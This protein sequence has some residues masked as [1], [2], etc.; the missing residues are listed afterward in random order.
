MRGSKRSSH[1]TTRNDLHRF[2]PTACRF[3]KF[4]RQ[5]PDELLQLGVLLLEGGLFRGVLMDFKG[6]CSI[7]QELVPPLI[8][9]RLADLLLV[10]ELGDRFPFEALKHDQGFGPCVPLALLHG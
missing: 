5:L 1:W 6:L 3:F 2:I 10:I 9:Q 8:V 4:E 7:C